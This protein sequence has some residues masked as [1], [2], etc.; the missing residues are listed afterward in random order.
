MKTIYLDSDFMCHL[1][2][3]EGRTA[4]E[5]DVFDG[6]VDAAI[7]YY[8]YIPQGEEWAEPKTGRVFHGLFIQA[9][10]SNAID[11]IVQGA[12]IADMQNALSILGVNA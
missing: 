4:V 9:T 12:F 8:R 2:D 3:G 6:I 1:E 11:R 5:T 7:P 10:D